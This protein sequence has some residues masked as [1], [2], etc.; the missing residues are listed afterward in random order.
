MSK[1]YLIRHG[2]T[3]SN[4]NATFQGQTN[5]PLS[6]LGRKQA[7]VL[8]HR[9]RKDQIKVDRLI[10]STLG[11]AIE[12]AQYISESIQCEIETDPE[13]QEIN[14][15]NW[16]GLSWNQISDKF[17]QYSDEYHEKWW[18]FKQHGGESW[19]E[20]L[21][22]FYSAVLRLVNTSPSKNLMIV[23]HGGV[24]RVLIAKL[25]GSHS[26]KPPLEISNTGITEIEILGDQMKFTR[27]NDHNHLAYCL[28]NTSQINES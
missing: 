10:A 6:K 2:E 18:Q 3:I 8:A 7:Q 9:L 20:A 12:T 17:P 5:S 25:L 24:I 26:P 23:A 16:E 19:T 27:I 22:R 1:I 13:L 21:E 15:G 4:A 28:P 11:R 14:L